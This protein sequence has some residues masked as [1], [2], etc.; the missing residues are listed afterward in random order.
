MV[1]VRK[2]VKLAGSG[3][4]LEL[5]RS[6]KCCSDSVLIKCLLIVL[7]LSDLKLQKHFA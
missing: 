3:V 1:V 5:R 6:C 2:G 4:S 7:L